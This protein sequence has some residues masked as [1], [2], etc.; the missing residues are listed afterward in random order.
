[1]NNSHR[2]ESAMD[3]RL[4]ENMLSLSSLVLSEFSPQSAIFG[5]TVELQNLQCYYN[6]SMPQIS[7]PGCVMSTNS[8]C[9]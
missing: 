2:I 6:L 9:L 3:M 8:F 4:A 1:M 7:Y 5:T